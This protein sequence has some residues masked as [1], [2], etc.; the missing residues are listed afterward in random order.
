[1]SNEKPKRHRPTLRS[2]TTSPCLATS[3]VS[4]ATS[5]GEE[6][7]DEAAAVAEAA[8]ASAGDPAFDGEPRPANR[9]CTKQEGVDK[10]SY[11]LHS[12]SPS[13]A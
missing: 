9:S 10:V 7:A 2:L 3:A 8:G 13:F 6:E 5:S 12:V 11:S 4:L 1:M